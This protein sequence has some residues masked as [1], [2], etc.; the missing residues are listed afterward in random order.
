VHKIMTALLE[1]KVTAMAGPADADGTASFIET[2]LKADLR[3]DV[4]RVRLSAL[5]HVRTHEL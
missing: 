1:R 2:A 4:Q 5:A 3:G